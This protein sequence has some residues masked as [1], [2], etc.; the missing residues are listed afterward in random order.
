MDPLDANE[1]FLPRLLAVFYATFDEVQGPVI[2]YQVPEGSIDGPSPAPLPLEFSCSSSSL[3]LSPADYF[4]RDSS[5]STSSANISFHNQRPPSPA[6]TAGTSVMPSK[7]QPLV[8]F[9]SILEYVIPKPQIS[10]RLVHC[11]TPR[12]RILG[13]PVVL[14]DARYTRHTLRFNLCFVFDRWADVSCYE[15]IVRKCARVLTECE[16]ESSFLTSPSGSQKLYQI[17]EQL[18][19][20][21]NSYSETSIY[22]DGFNS[23]ELKI[24]PF[25]PNP[26]EVDDWQVP[27]AL[28][29]LERR[30]D[31]NWDLA[32]TKVCPHINGVNH[33]RKIAELA[34]VSP[35]ATRLCMQHLLFYQCIMMVDIFQFSNMY[36]LTPSIRWLADDPS[37][38]EECGIYVTYPGHDLPSFP[39]LLHLY[40]RLKPGKTVH[41]WEEEN[42]VCALG[43]DVRR[44]I[45]FGVIKGF[46]RRVERWPVLIGVERG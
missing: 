31:R 25:Y 18:Y 36:T 23:L 32:I 43:V 37:V 35:E 7:R 24:F 20:D 38:I 39:R 40:T 45:S 4:S 17:I 13:F 5:P 28:L 30:R 8:D 41:M 42:G 26:P 15:P 44:F 22:I 21:L 6:P 9:N 46:L 29:N 2:V 27:I 11:N 33:V 3:P 12:H 14:R 19:E 16:K 10:G 1:S 34:D